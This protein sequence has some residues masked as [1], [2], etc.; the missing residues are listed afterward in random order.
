PP[1]LTWAAVRVLAAFTVR[2]ARPDSVGTSGRASCTTISA[3][4]L[5]TRRS[6]FG[7]SLL[8]ARRDRLSL[9]RPS[10]LIG[11]VGI[12]RS[13]PSGEL[14]TLVLASVVVGPAHELVLSHPVAQV[15]HC[16]EPEFL[17][18]E[19]LELKLSVTLERF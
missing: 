7:A 10:I 17:C 15:Q 16:A 1:A 19:E 18:Q 9:A 5:P 3:A 8:S 12:N 14:L 4:S 2:A 11:S 6:C 13:P